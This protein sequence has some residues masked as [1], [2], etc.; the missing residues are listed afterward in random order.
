MQNQLRMVTVLQ[1]VD[2]CTNHKLTKQTVRQTQVKN[3]ETFDGCAIIYTLV[4]TA[5]QLYTNKK[6]FEDA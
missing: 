6:C 4:K 5:K 2:R 3:N 1:L